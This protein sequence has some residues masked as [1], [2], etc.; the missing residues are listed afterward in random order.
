MME[1]LLF[2]PLFGPGL[3]LVAWLKPS[4]ELDRLERFI[5][6]LGLS[7]AF[8]PIF[9]LAFYE[10]GLPINRLVLAGVLALSWGLIGWRW[11]KSASFLLTCSNWRSTRPAALLPWV[12]LA[13]VLGLSAYVRIAVIQDLPVPMWADSYHH[14]M[15][16]QLMVDNNGLFSSWLPYAPLQTFT[17]HYG[18]HSLVANYHWLTGLDLPRAVLVTGQVLNFLLVLN[19]FLL[20]KVFMK[21]LWAAVMAALFVGLISPMPAFFFNWGRYTQLTGLA[22]LPIALVLLVRLLHSKTFDRKLVFLTA[23]SVAGLGLSHY[24]VVVF[25]VL[26]GA[27]YLAWRLVELRQAGEGL[28]P[29]A[30]NLLGSA[31]LTGL[32]TAPWIWNFIQGRFLTIVTTIVNQG[33]G[34]GPEKLKAHNQLPDIF[35][36]LNL[37]WYIVVIFGLIWAVWRRDKF[38]VVMALWAGSLILLANPHVAGLPGMGLINNFAVFISLFLPFSVLFGN[39]L[40]DVVVLALHVRTWAGGLLLVALLL[41]GVRSAGFRVTGFAPERQ[42]VTASDVEAMTWIRQNTPEDALF[43]INYGFAYS[44]SSIVGTDAG[45]WLPLLAH[46]QNLIPPLS[47]QEVP[48]PS[49]FNSNLFHRALSQNDLYGPAGYELL[50]EAGITHIYLGQQSGQVWNESQEVPF[51]PEKLVTTE[52]YRQVYHHDQVYVFEVASSPQNQPDQET[53]HAD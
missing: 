41:V 37:H 34:A 11:F 15:I 9:L 31:L 44:N 14:T 23:F 21:K 17:Y 38:A 18:F 1:Y 22:L 40:G 28:R 35:S 33:Q 5:L 2:L 46:R 30:Q 8:Y 42:L 49:D 53:A 4:P 36:F 39:L 24:G 52:F 26:F 10:L 32:I 3:A 7:L 19:G 27:I 50:Q 51:D 20:T 25:L 48:Y 6:G 12:G 43:L 45:W 13:M 16:S 47:F 29:L